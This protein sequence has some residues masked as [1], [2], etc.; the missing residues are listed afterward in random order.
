MVN[1]MYKTAISA[2]ALAL[3]A[4]SASAAT[5]D[6]TSGVLGGFNTTLTMP[7][8]TITAAPG[9]T[10]AVGDFIAN[11]VCPVTSG[12]AGAMTLTW[13][14]DVENVGFEYGFGNA[15][16]FATVTAFDASNNT[17]GSVSLTLTS[18]TASEDLSG[19]GVFRSLEFDNIGATGAG[20]AYGNVTFDRAAVIPLP[21]SLPLL[22]GAFGGLALLR[23][24]TAA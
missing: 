8:A 7:E 11:A 23:R 1:K 2:A 19:L 24:K 12:C 20:Y 10:L 22:L 14:F 21:A 16:D 15:G 13:N 9:T 4:S 18:G 17:V 3:A 6:F 5:L